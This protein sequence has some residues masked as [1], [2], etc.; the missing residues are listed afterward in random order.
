[1]LPDPQRI[2]TPIP[3]SDAP[4]LRKPVRLALLRA[5]G[6]AIAPF[7]ATARSAPA[8]RGADASS[9]PFRILLIRPDHLGDILFVTPAL[10]FLRAQAPGAHITALVGPWAKPVLERNPHLDAVQTV[11]FPGFTRRPKGSPLAP[12]AVLRTAARQ[13]H[14]QNFDAA[15]ILRFDHWWGALLAALAGIPRRT[16]YDV[17]EVKPFLSDALP[18]QADQHEVQQN[19][20]LA[21]RAVRA[22]EPRA[23]PQV[24][25]LEFFPAAADAEAVS[26]FLRANGI[27]AGDRFAVLV[28]GSGA[29]V[30]L[31]RT[32]GFARVAESLRARWQ[33][34]VVIAGAPEERPLAD[35][36]RAESSAPIA[37]SVGATT[38]PQLAALLVRAALVVGTDSGP[39][40]LAVA[41]QTPSV[42]LF[43]PVSARTFGPWGD[44]ARHIVLTS[45]LA[46][47]AC[48]RLDY[49]QSELS[50]HPCVPLIAERQVLAAAE[51][52]LSSR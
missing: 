24:F 17:P 9:K 11:E 52:A 41:M 1:M 35:Q 36:I 22:T 33:L 43:G 3:K 44:P 21:A 30:K 20:R 16:G 51:A 45:G 7:L 12:Y 26:N 40:H 28:P 2:P 8:I 46:C 13:L 25:P 19:L 4:S 37:S 42:H 50:A 14:A 39:M 18:Y 48:N 27:D 6:V 32:E 34:K 29:A 31:W 10:R 38:L 15:V 47:I 49:T 5:I 23:S